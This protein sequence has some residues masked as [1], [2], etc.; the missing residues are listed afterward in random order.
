MKTWLIGVLFVGALLAPGTASAQ[1]M[2]DP[3]VRAGFTIEVG[4]GLGITSAL[5]EEGDSEQKVGLSG[6]N[7]GLGLFV[8]PQLALLARFSGTLFFEDAG[9]ESHTFQNS[10]AMAAAQYW[11]NDKLFVGGGIGLGIFGPS[12]FDDL[13]VDDQ[14]GLALAARAGYTFALSSQSSWRAGVEVMP[15]FYDGVNV[16][17]TGL[18]VDWQWL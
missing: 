10:V 14:T 8:N 1:E 3:T 2:M 4:L 17:S 15:C 18:T 9:D 12:L 7:L 11:M 16:V 5:P 13:E 6:A